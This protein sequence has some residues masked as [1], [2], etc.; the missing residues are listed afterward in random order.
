MDKF[1]RFRSLVSDADPNL[2]KKFLAFHS[3]N[4]EV[5]NL[6]ERFSLEAKSAGRTRFSHWMVANRIRWFTTIETSGRD[7]K[8]SNDYI[9]LYARMVVAKHPELE[10]FFLLKEMK[11]NRVAARD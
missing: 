7:F 11:P 6:F 5:F 4:R 3:D 1:A 8:L 9:A 2:V 10:N